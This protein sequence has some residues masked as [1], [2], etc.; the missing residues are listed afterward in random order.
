MDVKSIFLNGD[1]EEEIYV[2]KPHGFKY[3][4]N[5]NDVYIL[6]KAL[7]GLKKAH[8]A[9]Y[10]RLEKYIQQQDF[11]TIVIGI[12]FY[13]KTDNENFIIIVVYVYDIIFGSD[14]AL[15]RKVFNKNAKGV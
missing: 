1:L 5:E 8:R 6:K 13:I 4:R 10:S 11:I 7:Y 3:S 9:W 15:M 2:E 14:G 12:N